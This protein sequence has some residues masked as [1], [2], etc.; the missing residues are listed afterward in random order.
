MKKR[1]STFA[2]RVGRSLSGEQKRLLSDYLEPIRI[3]SHEDLIPQGFAK[4]KLEIGFGN[5]EFLLQSCIDEPDCLY[6]GAEPYLNGVATLLRES[7]KLALPNLR[8]YT[9]DVRNILDP[10]GD[11]IFD[12]IHVICPDPWPKRRQHQR[13]LLQSNFVQLLAQKVKSG[14]TLIIVTDHHDYAKWIHCILVD[15]SL[16]K[17]DLESFS[18]LPSDWLFTK[19]QRRGIALGSKIY[20]FDIKVK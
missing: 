10:A 18:E 20:R 11:R 19:Y 3:H 1:V 14:G 7:E 6:I 15:L 13:R 12:A 2:R 17:S 16:T 8:V 4:M 5:G 9:D